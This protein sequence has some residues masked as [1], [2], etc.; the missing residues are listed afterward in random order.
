MDRLLRAVLV[1]LLS[2][3]LITPTIAEPVFIDY[4]AEEC[5][6]LPISSSIIDIGNYQHPP[7]STPVVFT[8][9]T[10]ILVP[11]S[12]VS[13]LSLSRSVIPSVADAQPIALI[14]K[15]HLTDLQTSKETKVELTERVNYV[16]FRSRRP[17]RS[18]AQSKQRT[19]IRSRSPRSGIRQATTLR[20]SVKA[21]R[22]S[23]TR[24]A[25]RKVQPRIATLR[26]GAPSRTIS[27][28]RK[29]NTRSYTQ[30][31]ANRK[32]NRYQSRPLI[33]R[34]SAPYR[35]ARVSYSRSAQRT[36]HYIA[37]RRFPQQRAPLS[38]IALRHPPALP[39]TGA[40]KAAAKPQQI[41]NTIKV[42]AINEAS[43]I[44]SIGKNQ[45]DFQQTQAQ[46]S[47]QP[48]RTAHQWTLP[49]H[50]HLLSTQR[51][52][53]APKKELMAS[54]QYVLKS[55]KQ[56]PVAQR[57]YLSVRSN[58]LSTQPVK[59][60]TA[61]SRLNMLALLPLRT[62]G[63]LIAPCPVATALTISPVFESLFN[64]KTLKAQIADEKR[65]RQQLAHT[66]SVSKWKAKNRRAMRMKIASNAL[67][68]AKQM[69][70]VGYC[71]RGV[72]LALRPLGINL[73]GM[74]A[75]MAK[76]QLNADP[77]FQRVQVGEI[78]ELH[79]G[80]VIVHGPTRSH[81]Y[82]HI[83]V[84]LGNENEA[85]DHVQKTFL[86]GPYSGVTVFRYEPTTTEAYSA[87]G[88]SDAEKSAS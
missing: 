49:T 75:Y 14:D 40:P 76:D 74:A 72:T 44:L 41:D 39:A 43:H 20:R 81:P 16:G 32:S 47:V 61:K 77:R 51:Q 25:S 83:G 35:N 50:Q 19:S 13:E 70:T 36:A 80:D 87:L 11:N 2:F 17:S 8:Q 18:A 59:K 10:E 86:K 26:R 5:L 68:T 4:S 66:K 71:Y 24:I 6:T 28:T 79:P 82:G 64:V 46:E 53:L 65:K 22:S 57:R 37:Q 15:G 23:S 7:D 62:L 34:R 85:S 38:Q 45:T 60:K 48:S 27:Q 9:K 21:S 33:T 30:A 73:S 69:N 54:H 58:L 1:A 42:T 63:T 67:N 56:L 29:R 31:N 3:P 78:A 52:I 84:Y 12:L 55:Q 88:L